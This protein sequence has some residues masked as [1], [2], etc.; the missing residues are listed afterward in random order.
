M[1]TYEYVDKDIYVKKI[2]LELFTRNIFFH[3][4]QLVS[5]KP[6]IKFVLFNNCYKKISINITNNFF[7]QSYKII[8]NYNCHFWWLY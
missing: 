2:D 4:S 7:V 8:T 3:N 5:K 1:G 6:S